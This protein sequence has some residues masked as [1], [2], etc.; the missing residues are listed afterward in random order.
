MKDWKIHVIV[1]LVYLVAFLAIT[2]PF[3]FAK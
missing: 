1:F 3:Y 2:A